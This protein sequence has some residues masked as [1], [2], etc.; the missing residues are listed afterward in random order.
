MST[1]WRAPQHNL[2]AGSA[3]LLTLAGK[4]KSVVASLTAHGR[5]DLPG[6]P[7][8]IS[9]SLGDA[10]LTGDLCS[11]DAQLPLLKAGVSDFLGRFLEVSGWPPADRK[12]AR[13][14]LVVRR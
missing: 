13:A 6:A 7:S 11:L 12:K 5:A 3:G 1:E 2:A 10:I 4:R 14:E 8:G 9:S